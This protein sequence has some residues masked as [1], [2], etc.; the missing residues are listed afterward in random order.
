MS[1]WKRFGD[2]EVVLSLVSV[3]QFAWIILLAPTLSVSTTAR[4]STFILAA[5]FLFG[6]IGFL[7][8]RIQNIKD[9]QSKTDDLKTAKP[10]KCVPFYFLVLLVSLCAIS[11]FLDQTVARENQFLGTEYSGARRTILD[12]VDFLTIALA[13]GLPG[14]VYSYFLGRVFSSFP[15]AVLRMYTFELIGAVLGVLASIFILDAGSWIKAATFMLAAAGTATC[16]TYRKEATRTQLACLFLVVVSTASLPTLFE[17]GGQVVRPKASIDDKLEL[18]EHSWTSYT[19]VQ[20]IRFQAIDGDREILTI[21]NGVS[22]VGLSNF[23]KQSIPLFIAI[24]ASLKPQ[25]VLILFAGAGGEIFSYRQAHPSVEKITGIELNPRIVEEAR[26]DG[27]YSLQSFFETYG[28]EL[29]IEDARVFIEQAQGELY[30]Q[31]I[32]SWSGSSAFGHPGIFLQTTSYAYTFEGVRRALDLIRPGGTLVFLGGPTYQVASV[33]KTD[34]KADL[35]NSFLTIRPM[36]TPDFVLGWD[37]RVSIFKKGAFSTAELSGVVQAAGPRA[38][39]DFLPALGVGR[40]AA[41]SLEQ[42]ITDGKESFD[43]FRIRGSPRTDDAPYVF[44]NVEILHSSEI[45]NSNARLMFGMLLAALLA[46]VISFYVKT[47][48]RAATLASFFGRTVLMGLS[49]ALVKSF[50]L[51]KGSLFFG[52]PTVALAVVLCA[53]LSGQILGVLL[54]ER[55]RLSKFA[56]FY[57]IPG[58]GVAVWSCFG[59]L[60]TKASPWI[61]DQAVEA[62]V[63][64]LGALILF[65]TA[66]SSVVFLGI[67]RGAGRHLSDSSASLVFSADLLASGAVMIFA[68]LIVNEIGLMN[69]LG[70]GLTALVLSALESL[71]RHHRDLRPV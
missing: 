19:K 69:T 62:R 9:G 18:L 12:T 21:G 32:Y 1:V 7:V 11:L 30:D 35:R 68:P 39:F 38:E 67:V 61:F 64:L 51:F 41:S 46:V 14:G 70:I 65:A 23:R 28:D 34:P 52:D 20:K 24:P 31:I 36:G 22:S 8:S 56:S 71:R 16:F 3:A 17:P 25:R 66:S 54:F 57:L 27:R 26:N 60:C 53:S 49:F 37:D 6:G 15:Q 2:I 42:F 44:D 63:L 29:R 55:F 58:L 5:T 33:L 45:L 10:E 13:V 4:D 48:V 47:K 59:I 43:R 50:A 40:R